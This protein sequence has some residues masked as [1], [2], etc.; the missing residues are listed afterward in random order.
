MNAIA[1]IPTVEATRSAA[2]LFDELRLKLVAATSRSVHLEQAIMEAE[3]EHADA[4]RDAR[5]QYQAEV[6]DLRTRLHA[7]EKLND[8]QAQRIHLLET[9]AA[10]DAQARE[11]M[12]AIVDLLATAANKAREDFGAS[13]IDAIERD[14]EA[15]RDQRFEPA[16]VETPHEPP[17]TIRRLTP[18]DRA[19]F[20]R[21][22]EQE[23]G[24][25][26]EDDGAP[27]PAFLRNGPATAPQ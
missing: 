16:T 4:M 12:V 13:V 21:R 3:R 5:E 10:I 23:V 6:N 17:V 20:F 24:S 9:N 19:N 27:I 26:A 8:H 22:L 1:E 11:R 7:S 15:H 14:R 25:A 2:E 18:E